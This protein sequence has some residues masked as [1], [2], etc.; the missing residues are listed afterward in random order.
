MSS[1]KTPV[2]CGGEIFGTTDLRLKTSL[3]M[4]PAAQK[5]ELCHSVGATGVV[6]KLT[7]GCKA[8][9][10]ITVSIENRNLLQWICFLSCSVQKYEKKSPQ[11]EI[12]S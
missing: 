5:A 7:S 3:H 12:D 6:F 4:H 1:G 10:I 9:T 11:D 2:P 8:F